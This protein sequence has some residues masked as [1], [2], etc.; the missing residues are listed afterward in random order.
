MAQPVRH[1]NGGFLW[2]YD[3]I[4]GTG[5]AAQYAAAINNAVSSQG[6]TLSNSGAD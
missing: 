5:L 4:V 3:D 1:I 6:F 2:L